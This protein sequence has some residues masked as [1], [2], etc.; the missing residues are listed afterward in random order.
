MELEE[1]CR[2]KRYNHRGLAVD[3]WI[4]VTPC[5]SKLHRYVFAGEGPGQL[6][7]AYDRV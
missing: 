5:A 4:K 7:A 3:I 2:Y 1:L 6:A